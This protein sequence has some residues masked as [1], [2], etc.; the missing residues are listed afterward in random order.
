MNRRQF[1]AGLLASTAV[2]SLPKI[3]LTDRMMTLEDFNW[4]ILQPLVK[5][6]E[7]TILY[8]NIDWKPVNFTDMTTI[9]C[10]E[11]EDVKITWRRL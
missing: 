8:G 4:R 2:P 10:E 1:L 3:P 6:W 7:H 11:G 5:E 9:T